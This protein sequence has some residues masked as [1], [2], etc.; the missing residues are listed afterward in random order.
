MK[1]KDSS[2]LVFRD[3]DRDYRMLERGSGIYL[4]DEDGKQYID[5]TSGSAAVANIGHGVPEVIEAIEQSVREYAYCPSHF[6]A[7]RHAMKLAELL[8][9][10]APEGLEYVWLVSDGSEATE[11]AVKFARQYHLVRGNSSKSLV[12]SR[13][14]SYHGATLSALG[15]GGE[16]YRRRSFLPLY[17]NMPHIPANY[18]YRCDYDLTYPDCGLRCAR[19]LEDEILRQGPDN[20][21]AFIAEP[22]VGAAL[23]AVPAVDGYF[24]TIREICD[25]Y[26]VVFIADEVMTGFGR[27]G[28][29]FG[30]DNWEVKPDIIAC[31]KGLTGG[32]VPLG[33]VIL[34]EKIIRTMVEGGQNVITGHTYSAHHLI[35]AAATAA[36][37]YVLDQDLVNRSR[38]AG[39]YFMKK[40][41]ALKEKE[42]VGDVRGKGLFIGI[43]FVKN[44][45]TKE[46]FPP[47]AQISACVGEAALENGLI[48]YPGTGSVKGASG[49]HILLAPPL[50]ISHDQI[51]EIVDILDR[52]ITI[53]ERDV[54]R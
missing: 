9:S 21:A 29:M 25:R 13:W 19:A 4:Y 50:T 8:A 24:A 3:F 31:A 2:A 53:V 22:V 6:F 42:I 26:D 51:D 52:A 7:N 32:Y 15:F 46:P 23:G 37:Q 30:I 18:C 39:D 35:A 43:E 54:N 27:T 48:T 36:V 38:N 34:H 10:I 14:N 12:I 45:Q 1:G 11:T 49:D 47:E 20:V 17:Q 28:C 33:A 40:L 16:S 44:K 41:L 5:G